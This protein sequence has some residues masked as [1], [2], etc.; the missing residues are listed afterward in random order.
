[1]PIWSA[2]LPGVTSSTDSGTDMS[3]P[4]G[5]S[6]QTT[7]TTKNICE[8]L[9]RFVVGNKNVS[10]NSTLQLKTVGYLRVR[11]SE[12]DELAHFFVIVTIFL[13]AFRYAV[14]INCV[15]GCQSITFQLK[16]NNKNTQKA[17]ASKRIS[18]LTSSQINSTQFSLFFSFRLFSHEYRFSRSAYCYLTIWCCFSSFALECVCVWENGN[19]SYFFLISTQQT[20]I[21]VSFFHSVRLYGYNV[22]LFIN[23]DNKGTLYS[24]RCLIRV[25]A[26]SLACV[27]VCVCAYNAYLLA[28]AFVGIEFVRGIT[29]HWYST[30]AIQLYI[31]LQK[32]VREREEKNK[33]EWADKGG[34]L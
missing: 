10:T 30:I 16:H 34:E 24:N 17:K 11:T 18:Y 20:N 2:M 29:L 8:R 4:P 5:I 31:L 14:R 13:C 21:F 26:S 7:T 15:L 23:S 3:E 6:V 12:N 22:C 28:F 25:C 32:I 33:K 27:C 1:M 9:E 19:W